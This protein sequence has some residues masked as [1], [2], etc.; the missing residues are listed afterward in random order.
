[1]RDASRYI[2][3]SLMLVGIVVML[4]ACP[5]KGP[6]FAPADGTIVTDTGMVTWIDGHGGFYGIVN[7]NGVRY[8][9]SILPTSLRKDALE[10]RFVGRIKTQ[11][12]NAR[13]WGWPIEIIRI[14]EVR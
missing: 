13:Q 4:G 1:M 2:V 3:R 12:P 6:A 14:E 11:Q 9:P 7:E 5:H 10:V 8:D